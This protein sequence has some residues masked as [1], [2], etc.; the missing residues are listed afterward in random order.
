MAIKSN[1]FIKKMQKFNGSQQRQFSEFLKTFSASED[2]RVYVDGATMEKDGDDFLVHEPEDESITR[3]SD[4][5]DEVN[6]MDETP[7]IDIEG[8]D[9]EGEEVNIEVEP[10]EE[11]EI[12]IK[13]EDKSMSKLYSDMIKVFSKMNRAQKQSLVSGLNQ[14]VFSTHSDAERIAKADDKI[15]NE[16]QGVQDDLVEH[17]TAKITS[18]KNDKP[19]VEGQ[20][21][22]PKT[23]KAVI[24]PNSKVFAFEPFD[25]IA[26]ILKRAGVSKDKIER[27][28]ETLAGVGKQIEKSKGFS[29]R[30]FSA[31]TFAKKKGFEPFDL[32]AGTLKRLGV[33]ADKIEKIKSILGEAGEQIER[34]KGLKSDKTFAEGD[35]YVVCSADCEEVFGENLSLE[36]AADVLADHPG[37]IMQRQS[38]FESEEAEDEGSEEEVEVEEEDKEFTM[39]ATAE[40]VQEAVSPTAEDL[41]SILGGG[42]PIDPNRTSPKDRIPKPQVEGEGQDLRPKINPSQNVQGSK[43]FSNSKNS[44]A[45]NDLDRILARKF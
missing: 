1:A 30:V 43:T 6:F 34:S 37:A 40:E 22:T 13:G 25:L 36:E 45:D 23:T 8:G 44:A 20:D 32:I 28:R 21:D 5:G 12:T 18:T 11:V 17:R 7:E 24:S 16:T 27:I 15:I 29:A 38:D 41:D 33:K 2:N 35:S 4:S 19:K 42:G 39:G 31:K 14:K 10:G 9:D 26:G 3:I